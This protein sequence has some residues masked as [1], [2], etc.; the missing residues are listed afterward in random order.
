MTT[1]RISVSE[2]KA[3]CTVLLRDVANK[4]RTLEVTNHGRVIAM[5]VPPIEPGGLDPAKWMGS[6]RGT[7]VRYEEPSAPTTASGEWEI[8]FD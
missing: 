7:V 1:L 8:S 5:V 3:H 2:F 6:L 4:G